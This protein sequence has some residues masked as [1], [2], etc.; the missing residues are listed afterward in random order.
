M[1]GDSLIDARSRGAAPIMVGREA[2]YYAWVDMRRRCQDPSNRIY[3]NYGGRGISVCPR[4]A[5]SF[6]AFYEDVGPRPDGHSL[7]RIDNDGNYSPEN[8]RWETPKQQ[9]RN[10][11]SNRLIE[12]FGESKT[13]PEWLEDERCAVTNRFAIY[14]RIG[15]GWEPERAITTPP[16]PNGRRVRH[17]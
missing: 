17:A 12:A 9:S 8:V 2:E 6:E 15:R 13:A 4:W 14:E 3:A 10:R 11:R 5:Q 7:G 1:R 16:G